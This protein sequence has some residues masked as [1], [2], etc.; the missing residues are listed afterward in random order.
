MAAGFSAAGSLVAAFFGAGSL[1]PV[2][3]PE[4]QPTQQTVNSTTQASKNTNSLLLFETQ[5]LN[6]FIA[7]YGI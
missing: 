7:P 5:C 1:G 2:F 6:I 3:L 4:E